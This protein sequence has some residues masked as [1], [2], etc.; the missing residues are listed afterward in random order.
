M[1]APESNNRG[2]EKRRYSERLAVNIQ[3]RKKENKPHI[4]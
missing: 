1:K 4:I 2:N 3:E